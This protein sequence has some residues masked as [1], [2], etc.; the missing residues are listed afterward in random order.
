MFLYIEKKTIQ[1]EP[2]TLTLGR[3]SYIMET[4]IV[5]SFDPF[6]RESL[7]QLAVF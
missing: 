6:D 5:Q 7:T 3:L 4:K 1:Q 2:D